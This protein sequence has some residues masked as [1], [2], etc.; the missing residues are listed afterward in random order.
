[1]LDLI[2]INDEDGTLI[3]AL[4]SGQTVALPSPLP[5]NLPPHSVPVSSPNLCSYASCAQCASR[6]SCPL[7]M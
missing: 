2:F 3:P 7:A 6:P 5:L 1:M 4:V